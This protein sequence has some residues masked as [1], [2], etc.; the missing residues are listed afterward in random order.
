MTRAP[1]VA[2][3]AKAGSVTSPATDWTPAIG[4]RSPERLTTRTDSPRRA[5]ASATAIP[6][7]P[8]PSTTWSTESITPRVRGRE[9]REEEAAEQHEHERA[10]GA[11]HRELVVDAD[12]GDRCRGPAEREEHRHRERPW[13]RDRAASLPGEH[14]ALSGAERRAADEAHQGERAEIG[15]VADERGAG[16]Q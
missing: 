10:A 9:A 5:S 1:R 16:R 2:D 6:T 15:V 4:S 7:A 11:E 14:E 12:A 8:A 3:A 13:R